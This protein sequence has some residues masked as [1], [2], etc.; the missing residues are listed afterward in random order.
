M[1]IFICLAALAVFFL[2]VMAV[3]CNRFVIR[4]YRCRIGKL[5]RDGR[6]VLLSDL[7]GK[8]FGRD[9]EK[10]LSAIGRVN[11]DM[12]WIAGDMYTSSRDGDTQTARGLISALSRRYPV[13]YA[14]GNHEQKTRLSP[15]DFGDMY[16]DFAGEIERLGVRHLVNERVYLPE[17][18]M[19]ICGA[20]IGFEYYGKFNKKKM[21]PAYLTQL[22]GKPDPARTTVLL[23]H[24]PDFFEA[25][26]QWGADL[27]VSGHIH[28]GL[29]RVPFL[30]GAISPSLKL[31]PRYDGGEFRE[32]EAVMILGRGLGTHTLPIRIF[33]P[34]ELV[35]IELCR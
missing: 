29:M 9:N 27:T 8:S 18:N 15:E 3:D 7:H 21:E 22:L 25:Y 32:G 11:P 30:G 1:A 2:L 34:G 24:N 19:E 14:N 20:E 10:L 12:I 26:A 4:T 17:F 33:N 35:V 6:V 16:Q 5:K 28:G 31:F 23:A 13:Y